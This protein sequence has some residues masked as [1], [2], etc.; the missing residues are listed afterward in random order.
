MP[1][2]VRRVPEGDD[3]ERSVCEICG[4]VDY[5]NP[6]VIV[7]SVVVAGEA[8]LLCRRGIEPRRGFWTL[9]AGFLE[10]NET[11][12]E[13]AAREAW[14]E[15]RARIAVEGILGIF[16]ISR[17]G[18]VQVIFRAKFDGPVAYESG[19]ESQDVQLFTFATIPWSQIAFPSVV[20]SLQAW[21]K[22]AGRPLGPPVGNPPDDP[23]GMRR[24]GMDAQEGPL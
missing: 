20:W 3:R 4:F 9:P 12:E 13:G 19:P 10:L 6:R 5:Q 1:R 22:G 11:I 15:A 8:V 18:Q 24:P 2:F 16:N 17:I 7:G 23:R 14:E 21:W